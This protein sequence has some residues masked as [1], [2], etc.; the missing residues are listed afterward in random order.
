M[1]YF[2]GRHT[3]A[4]Q[5]GGSWGLTLGSVIGDGR[6]WL[7]SLPGGYEF[8]GP[9]HRTGQTVKDRRV[10]QELVIC[11]DLQLRDRVDRA[12]LGF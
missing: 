8:N 7:A 5:L 1:V 2:E 9:C 3:Q 12:R 4:D 10:R 11:R 6:R